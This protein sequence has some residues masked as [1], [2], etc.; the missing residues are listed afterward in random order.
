MKLL[1]FLCLFQFLFTF[2]VGL[3]FF[4][5][6]YVQAS[7]VSSSVEATQAYNERYEQWLL[8]KERRLRALR[9]KL[10]EQRQAALRNKAIQTPPVQRVRAKTEPAKNVALP[11][12]L[13]AKTVRQPAAVDDAVIETEQARVEEASAPSERTPKLRDAQSEF[14]NNI[15]R[16]NQQVQALLSMIDHTKV[17]FSINSDGRL[18]DLFKDERFQEIY[19]EEMTKPTRKQTY[20]FFKGYQDEN[21]NPNEPVARTLNRDVRI[22]REKIDAYL[23]TT[24]IKSKLTRALQGRYPAPVPR[25]VESPESSPDEGSGSG[26]SVE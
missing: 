16:D 15:P 17:Y 26:D 14:I 19:R 6:S 20:N 11:T 23:Q 9:Q 4:S 5:E 10:N 2:K 18:K 24:G 21:R 12:A 13:P 7:E 22:T 1:I 25:S 3:S 8:N